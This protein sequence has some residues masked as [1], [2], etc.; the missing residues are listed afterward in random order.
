VFGGRAGHVPMTLSMAGG[1]TLILS[2]GALRSLVAT[3][4]WCSDPHASHASLLHLKD[5][6]ASAPKRAAFV[7]RQAS[8]FGIMKV[9]E[10]HLSQLKPASHDPPNPD[11]LESAPPLYRPRLLMQGMA[12]CLELGAANLLWPGQHNGDCDEIAATSEQ[13]VLVEHLVQ[14]SDDGLP[15]IDAP[16]LELTNVQLLEL[17][18]QL[19]V[20]WEL[21]W[22]CQLSGDKPCLICPSCRCRHDAFEEAGLLDPINAHQT[23]TN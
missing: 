18:T 17:G 2:S 10:I 15:R 22:S 20:P 16:L 4:A 12:S 6:R 8:H 23:A 1:S 13:I 9:H 19:Q 14:L 5:N 21:A 3:A 11:H 7:R